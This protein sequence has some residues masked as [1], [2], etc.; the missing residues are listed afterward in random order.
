MVLF[1]T[2]HYP[3]RTSC[4]CCKALCNTLYTTL[5]TTVCNTQLAFALEG[6]VL[7]LPVKLETPKPKGCMREGYSPRRNKIYVIRDNASYPDV[8]MLN[9]GFLLAR[10]MQR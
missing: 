10:C 6:R 3:A 2:L 8:V 4:T 9:G 7:G 5:C 1:C